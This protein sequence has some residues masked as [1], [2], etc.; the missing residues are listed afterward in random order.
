[1]R[2]RRKINSGFTP[3]DPDVANF[4]N[5]VTCLTTQQKIAVQTFIVGLKTD[6]IY[7][8]LDRLYLNVGCSIA[9]YAV[10]FITL[11]S[12]IQIGSP[13]WHAN[14]TDY[15]GVTNSFQA[16][17]LLTA[18]SKLTSTSASFGIVTDS[19]IGFQDIITGT[20]KGPVS[21]LGAR[22]GTNSAILIVDNAGAG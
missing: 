17:I 1:M 3:T 21:P 2:D 6:G 14:G 15:D 22:D 10:D 13:T 19:I 11:T 5:V 9:D 18:S 4:L 20:G 8:K 7:S 12:R 16:D